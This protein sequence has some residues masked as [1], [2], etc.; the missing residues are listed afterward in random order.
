MKYCFRICCAF[1]FLI[2]LNGFAQEKTNAVVLKAARMIDGKSNTVVE[3]AIVVIENEK[4]ISAGA[5]ASIPAGASVIDLGSVTILPGLIDCHDHLTADP[6]DSGYN[7]LGV[8]VP[9]QAL[10]G[11]SNA[12]KTLEAGFTTVRNVGA[13]AYTDV[14]LRDAVRDGDIEGPRMLVSGPALGITGGHCDSNLLAP[15]FHFKEDG[16]ADGPWEARAKVREVIKYGADVIKI[17]ASGGV[18]SKGDLPGTPQYTPEEMTAIVQEAHRLG[19][20]VAAHAHGTQSIK[21]AV[22]AGV[23]SIEH[24]SMID[25]EGIR[26]A[27]E[28]GTFLVMDIYNDDF[29][30]QHGAEVGMLP[31]S[32]EKERQ[33][34]QLQR[35]NFSKA[36]RGG[37][38]MAFGSDGGV[39]PHGDNAR[40]FFYMVKYGMTPMQAIQSATSQAAE[41][42]GWNDQV[43]TIE[44]G[45]YADIIAVRE[46]PLQNIRALE[47]VHFVMKGGVIIKNEAK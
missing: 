25:E 36:F 42:I 39:Y 45:K 7:S 18:L 17:C 33:I 6:E 41:L 35:D 16:V 29:I 13:G 23:D 2:S 5:M 47:T 21:E 12:R 15:E 14:A 44:A 40:Q 1:L 22:I 19:R 10:H 9:A 38:R 20:K 43:G 26:L 46:D 11:A 34:G 30:L 27:K 28:K 8:S 32:L 24:A 31:E 4:I 3:N 37:A